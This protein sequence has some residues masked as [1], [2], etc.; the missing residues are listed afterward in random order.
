MN[1]SIEDPL[2]LSLD[3]NGVNKGTSPFESENSLNAHNS[4]DTNANKKSR[5]VKTYKCILEFNTCNE[6]I[7]RLKEPICDS[8]YRL[9]Y[10]RKSKNL[11]HHQ[12]SNGGILPPKSVAHIKK[13]FEE[14][15]KYSNNEIISKHVCI[16]SL[17]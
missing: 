16:V 12:E 1:N 5:V 15:I 10:T 6:A 9:R 4:F 11:H 13:L 7:E 3:S 17:I 14:K 8:T 2:L